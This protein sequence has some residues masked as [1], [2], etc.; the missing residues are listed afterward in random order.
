VQDGQTAHA[1]VEH[2][3]RPRIHSAIV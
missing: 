2:A 1:R 3:H